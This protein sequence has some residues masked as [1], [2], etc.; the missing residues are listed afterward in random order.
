[1]CCRIPSLSSANVRRL[2]G[3]SGNKALRMSSN[4]DCP[5]RRTT[6]LSP[7][8]S[9]SRV[10]P[11]P[12]PSLRRTSRGTEICPCAVTFECASAIRLHYHGNGSP[13]QSERQHRLAGRDGDVLA[14]VQRVADRRGVD[15]AACLESP[16]DFPA[17]GVE[18]D[19]VAFGVATK[20]ES[21]GGCEDT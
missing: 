15:G 4:V 9:H 14:A 20:H 6:I 12:I 17:S 10:D 18:G 7:S 16:E 21:A 5:T 11:G 2:G 8:S 1:M 13:R 19:Q 3:P